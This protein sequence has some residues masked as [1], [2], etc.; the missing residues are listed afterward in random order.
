MGGYVKHILWWLG[1]FWG[2]IVCCGVRVCVCMCVYMCI[3][4]FAYACVCQVDVW[5]HDRFNSEDFLGRAII[6]LAS[7]WEESLEA[8]YP[9][10][11]GSP[12]DKVEGEILLNLQFCYKQDQFEVRL[13]FRVHTPTHALC[14][15]SHCVTPLFSV[16]P[17]L[18]PL[19]LIMLSRISH[20]LQRLCCHCT[21][22]RM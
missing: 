12:K 6:P 10:G 11:R 13:W 8:W 21:P 1:F 19:P 18:C 17:T 5:D 3:L 2:C 15:G 20:L 16:V 4:H 9:L 22:I 14:R 7:V